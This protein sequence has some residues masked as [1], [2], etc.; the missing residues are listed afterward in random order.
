MGSMTWYHTVDTTKTMLVAECPICYR[1][2]GFVN[3][4]SGTVTVVIDHQPTPGQC[5]MYVDGVIATVRTDRSG[6]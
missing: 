1:V 2:H 4:P 3:P 5:L 6:E